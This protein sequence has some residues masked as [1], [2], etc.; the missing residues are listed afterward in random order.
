MA[1]MGG[2][3]GIDARRRGRHLWDISILEYY[4]STEV[5]MFLPASPWSSFAYP[6]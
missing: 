6:L 4:E 2:A 5:G 1:F 3:L